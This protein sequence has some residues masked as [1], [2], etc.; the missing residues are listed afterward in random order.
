MSLVL[1]EQEIL[2]HR[3]DSVLVPTGPK[4]LPELLARAYILHLLRAG[5]WI[6]RTL[7]VI[8]RGI[9]YLHLTRFLVAWLLATSSLTM[10]LLF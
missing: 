7:E 9:P 6:K 8:S 1:V 3:N 4:C 2:N 5:S 10:L